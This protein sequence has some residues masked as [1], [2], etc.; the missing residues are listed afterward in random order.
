M[1]FLRACA[2]SPSARA[3][4]SEE[5]S[6]SEEPLWASS[7][8]RLDNGRRTRLKRGRMKR[9]VGS[10][11]ERGKEAMK[12]EK[13]GLFNSRVEAI[14]EDFCFCLSGIQ[15]S[16]ASTTFLIAISFGVS[17]CSRRTVFREDTQVRVD[18]IAFLSKSCNSN[19]FYVFPVPSVLFQFS[20]TLKLLTVVCFQ[21]RRVSLFKLFIYSSKMPHNKR[22]SYA[23]WRRGRRS[24]IE[25]GKIG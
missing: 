8:W 9:S 23:Q 11:E 24:K 2:Q 15:S 21:L 7:Q 25:G 1:V 20:S 13:R 4:V 14:L 17:C 22:I 10:K 18:N 16:I 3:S 19:P 6:V 12:V 5:K